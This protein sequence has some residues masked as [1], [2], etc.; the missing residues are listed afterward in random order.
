MNVLFV[1][2]SLACVALAAMLGVNH[3]RAASFSAMGWACAIAGA[4]HFGANL[5]VPWLLALFVLPISVFP[6]FLLTGTLLRTTK[7]FHR[8]PLLLALLAAPTSFVLA[9]NGATTLAWLIIVPLHLLAYGMLVTYQVRSTHSSERWPITLGISLAFLGMALAEIWLAVATYNGA[10]TLYAALL[11]SCAAAL[12]AAS[13][14]LWLINDYQLSQ[15]QQQELLAATMSRQ[16]TMHENASDLTIES[17]DAGT[18]TYVSP[19]LYRILGHRAEDWIGKE[20]VDMIHPDDRPL[21]APWRASAELAAGFLSPPLRSQ[22]ADGS[23]HS[24]EAMSRRFETDEGIRMVAMCRDITD[25]VNRQQ[26]LAAAQSRLKTLEDY[27]SDIFF[28][29][30][31]DGIIRYVSPAVL[32]LTGYTQQQVVGRKTV[33]ILTE[34]ETTPV[35]HNTLLPPNSQA[36][37]KIHTMTKANGET[38]WVEIEAAGFTDETGNPGL[39]GSIRDITARIEQQEHTHK[40]R[41]LESIC[42]L[43]GG[44]AHD[45]NNLM[46]IIRGN[47]E[48][49]MDDISQQ[50][51]NAAIARL[52]TIDDTTER[53]AELTRKLLTY[54]GQKTLVMGS[55]DL[56]EVVRGTLTGLH[57]NLPGHIRLNV[58]ASGAAVM[59]KADRSQLQQMVASLV[60]NAIEACRAK[61]NEITVS[62][63][64]YQENDRVYACLTVADDGEGMGEATLQKIFDPF[65]TTREQGRGLG[66]AAVFG[67]VNAHQGNIAVES[68]MAKG[69]LIKV[70]LPVAD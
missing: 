7:V 44:V 13:H 24:F 33:D 67:I 4:A 34:V 54:A 64:L 46:G 42:Q 36:A 25:R 59:V 62:A 55:V 18:M 41:V 63:G 14:V 51:V 66:L 22:H 35:T 47:A 40:Q 31:H 48:L 17:R 49:A 38:L 20:L 11:W 15:Y 5:Q 10:S 68:K 56:L 19:N 1:T 8:W 45:V 57:N 37:G 70:T 3:K 28:E 32:A 52:S 30:G 39:I 58:Q 16:Q 9:S 21:L 23:W 60:A 65:F 50:N 2:I 53:V 26:E 69:T 61:D 12:A 6:A 43:A 29:I 27:S